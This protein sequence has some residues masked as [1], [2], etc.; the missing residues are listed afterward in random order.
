MSTEGVWL[1]SRFALLGV[2]I[3]AGAAVRTMVGPSKRRGRIMTAGNIGGLVVGVL[4]GV[5]TSS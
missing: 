2:L 1:V 3:L 5:A 4:L